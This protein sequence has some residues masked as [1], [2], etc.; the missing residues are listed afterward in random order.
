MTH[1]TG[2][3]RGDRTPIIIDHHLAVF[4]HTFRST[5]SIL[6]TEYTHTVQPLAV[7]EATNDLIESRLW[8]E[9][10]QIDRTAYCATQRYVHNYRL[11]E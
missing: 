7:T 8:T 4:A 3:F 1:A 11:Q 9:E 5:Q 2:P 6:S 10:S